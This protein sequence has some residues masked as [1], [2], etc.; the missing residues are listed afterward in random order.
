MVLG[1]R[2][3]RGRK[4]LA[5]EGRSAGRR[6]HRGGEGRPRKKGP[7][8]KGPPEEGSGRS[9]EGSG[10]EGSGKKGPAEEVVRGRRVRIPKN[11]NKKQAC[12]K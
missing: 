8:K 3:R 6:V 9:E 10:E 2:V 4:G 7:R 12:K 11:D 5:E 1:R